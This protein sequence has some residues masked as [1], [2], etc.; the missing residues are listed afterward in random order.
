MPELHSLVLD[1]CATTYNRRRICNCYSHGCPQGYATDPT[2]E[3]TYS[4]PIIA[5]YQKRIFGSLLECINIPREAPHV[6][7]ETLT[8]SQ[9]SQ[10]LL[11]G[12]Y[13]MD[14]AQAA[15]ARR[16]IGYTAPSRH[17]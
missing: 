9:K 15:Q 10:D 4:P 2:R 7:Y 16:S 1:I 3:C 5:T 11:A 12:R 14:A 17:L 8:G 13:G 6:E